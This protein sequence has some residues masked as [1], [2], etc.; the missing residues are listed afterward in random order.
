MVLYFTK[1]TAAVVL[2]ARLSLK[3]KLSKKNTKED[4]LTTYSQVLNQLLETYATDEAIAEVDNNIMRFT[5][6]RNL[7]RPQFADTL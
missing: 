1:R 4:V 3:P 2:T 7:T 5:Q 6:S